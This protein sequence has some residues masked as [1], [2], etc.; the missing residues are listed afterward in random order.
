MG[1]SL[2]TDHNTIPPSDTYWDDI[3]QFLKDAGVLD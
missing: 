3:E 2:G 1:Y